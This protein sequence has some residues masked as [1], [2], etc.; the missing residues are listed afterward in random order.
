MSASETGLLSTST[1]WLTKNLD[2][3]LYRALSSIVHGSHD[4]CVGF[5]GV[6]IVSDRAG[7]AK[8]NEWLAYGAITKVPC[9]SC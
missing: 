3:L 6:V 4:D 2:I 9:I 7:V 5:W 8:A 1:N